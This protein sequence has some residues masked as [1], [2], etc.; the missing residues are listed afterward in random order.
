VSDVGWV[1]EYPLR[2]KGV[3]D[4]VNVSKK[5]NLIN[6]NLNNFIQNYRYILTDKGNLKWHG[7]VY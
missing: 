7:I 6:K 4:L 3:G 1:G 5:N 2:G